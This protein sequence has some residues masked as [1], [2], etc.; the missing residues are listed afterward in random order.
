MSAQ[1][2]P[3]A[4]LGQVAVPVYDDRA[5]RPYIYLYERCGQPLGGPHDLCRRALHVGPDGRNVG[6]AIASTEGEAASNRARS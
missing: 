1:P 3:P 6:H 5:G 4:D 2:L